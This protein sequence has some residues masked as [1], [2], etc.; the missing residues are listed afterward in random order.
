[1]SWAEIWKSDWGRA[2]ILIATLWA[3]L[4]FGAAAVFVAKGPGDGVDKIR[5]LASKKHVE[6]KVTNPQ[7]FRDTRASTYAADLEWVSDSGTIERQPNTPTSGEFYDRV[8]GQSGQGAP[9]NVSVRVGEIGGKPVAL[10]IDDPRH[11]EREISSQGLPFYV[12]MTFFG[13]ALG[14]FMTLFIIKHGSVPARVKA[15]N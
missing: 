12:I 1:M 7:K 14:T 5:I 2:S 6:A 4:A 9:T 13:L 10:I 11:I 8:S 15:G 3:L